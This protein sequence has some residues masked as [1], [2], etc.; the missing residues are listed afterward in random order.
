MQV[1]VV[2]CMAVDVFGLAGYGSASA[3]ATGGVISSMP[4]LGGVGAV[5]ST[6]CAARCEP[7]EGEAM[8]ETASTKSPG[9]VK[10]RRS[11]KSTM[12]RDGGQRWQG[13][14]AVFILASVQ[15]GRMFF[16]FRTVVFFLLVGCR[17]PDAQEK[18]KVQ[19]GLL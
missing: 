4:S 5:K 18:F 12:C 1:L 14:S 13:E 9:C 3:L 17:L 7:A 11:P 16:F 19:A 6:A 2:V 8:N 15:M 10:P